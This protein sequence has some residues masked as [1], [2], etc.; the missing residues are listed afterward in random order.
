M[1]FA[2]DPPEPSARPIGAS[3]TSAEDGS[4]PR[5]DLRADGLPWRE[6]GPR[7]PV[8]LYASDA[9]RGAVPPQSVR[10]AKEIEALRPSSRR[11]SASSGVLRGNVTAASNWLPPDNVA[12]RRGRWTTNLSDTS[13]STSLHRRRRTWG[14]SHGEAMSAFEDDRILQS[15]RSTWTASRRRAPVQ[16]VHHRRP[17]PCLASSVDISS[18][19]NGNFVS[20]LIATE[21]GI[22]GRARPVRRVAGDHPKVASTCCRSRAG[23]IRTERTWTP[24]W[25]D[26]GHYDMVISEG[27]NAYF[28]A[29][30]SAAPVEAWRNSAEDRQRD[31]WRPRQSGAAFQSWTGTAF[32]YFTPDSCSPTRGRRSR[33]GCAGHGNPAREADGGVPGQ[34]ECGTQRMAM[35]PSA[36]RR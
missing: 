28:P 4:H 19:D 32:E 13:V 23:L 20:F 16:L 27:R 2:F 35:R 26:P 8:E 30:C 3:S 12:S 9:L 5:E 7:E 29:I 22:G 24:G 14:S 6:E 36:H 34:S 21:L 31:R 18:V 15:S 10:N 17:A 11:C 1:A 33:G 25:S